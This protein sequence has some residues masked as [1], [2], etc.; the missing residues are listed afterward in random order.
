[1]TKKDFFFHAIFLAIAVTGFFI[2]GY[3]GGLLTGLFLAIL[4]FSSIGK[5]L[6]LKAGKRIDKHMKDF[7]VQTQLEKDAD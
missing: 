5:I 1:M 6:A 3:W 2:G 4:F 7:I